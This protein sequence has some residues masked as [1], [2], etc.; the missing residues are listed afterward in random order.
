MSTSELKYQRNYA[1]VVPHTTQC[2]R[3]HAPVTQALL[4]T[5]QHSKQFN[6]LTGKGGAERA[7]VQQ[8]QRKRNHSPCCPIRS[9]QC[10]PEH[11]GICQVCEVHKAFIVHARPHRLAHSV[12][13][14]GEEAEGGGLR[15]RKGWQ[16]V[17]IKATFVCAE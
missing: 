9:G 2:Q 12:E 8:N 11:R 3:N 16:A 4:C 1:P 5:M 14:G 15:M 7:R 13:G 6:W 10:F 17:V